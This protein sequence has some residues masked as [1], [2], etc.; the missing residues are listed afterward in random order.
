MSPTSGGHE[1]R[2]LSPTGLT[3]FKLSVALSGPDSG[4]EEVVVRDQSQRFSTTQRAGDAGHVAQ[5]SA[6]PGLVP[7]TTTKEGRRELKTGRNVVGED[8]DNT[9][10][11]NPRFLPVIE[12]NSK[13]FVAQGADASAARVAAP[14]GDDEPW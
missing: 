3:K 5:A 7:S 14:D 6:S 13:A 1:A 9:E 8:D 4:E 12:R 10:K 2:S 11:A